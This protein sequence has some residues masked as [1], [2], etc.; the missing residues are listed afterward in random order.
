[1]DSW[2]SLLP[3]A[4]SPIWT[5]PGP[6]WLLGV[7]AEVTLADNIVDINESL[8]LMKVARFIGASPDDMTDLVGERTAALS[9]LR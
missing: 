3:M 1:M 8:Y 4:L 5:L 7:V 6:D 9:G 2:M